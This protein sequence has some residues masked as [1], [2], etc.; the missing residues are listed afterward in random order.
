MGKLG[1]VLGKLRNWAFTIAREAYRQPS[2]FSRI[3]TRGYECTLEFGTL[4]APS[5]LRV[6]VLLR[7][8][9]F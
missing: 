8:V 7:Q 3:G 9:A 6:G 2:V 4:S 1:E 5:I